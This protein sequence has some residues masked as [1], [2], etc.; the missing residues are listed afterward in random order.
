MVKKNIFISNL[1]DWLTIILRLFFN[2]KKE[3]HFMRK[4]YIYF[5]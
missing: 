5:Y 2:K 4:K 1:I 3:N